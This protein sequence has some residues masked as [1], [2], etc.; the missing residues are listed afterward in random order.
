MHLL[1]RASKK[2]TPALLQRKRFVQAFLFLFG[3]SL[4]FQG[5]S[6]VY[7]FYVDQSNSTDNIFSSATLNAEVTSTETELQDPVTAA[8]MLPDDTVTVTRTAT[9]ENIGTLDF[10]YRA[11]FV[12]NAGSDTAL[13]DALQLTATNDNGFSWTGDLSSFTGSTGNAGTLTVGDDHDWL[14]SIKL[15]SGASASLQDLTCDFDFDFVAWQTNLPDETTGFS[16]MEVITNNIIH[17]AGD[18]TGPVITNLRGRFQPSIYPIKYDDRGRRLFRFN[19][20]WETDEL[21][22]SNVRYDIVNPYPFTDGYAYQSPIAIDTNADNTLHAI[23]ID[24][25]FS[26][27]ADF[28]LYFLVV[29]EDSNGNE[30]IQY[31]TI[32]TGRVQYKNDVVLNEF[33]PNPDSNEPGVNESDEYIELFNR[34]DRPVDVA[35]WAIY[36]SNDSHEVIITPSNTNTG[37]TLILP[38]GRL[39][40]YLEDTILN[41]S[42]GDTVRIYDDALSNG[43]RLVDEYTYTGVAP[44]GKTY[45]RIPDGYGPIVDPEP[46]PGEKNK[47]NKKEIEDFRLYTLE[48]C[49]DGERLNEKADNTLCNPLF[50][51][52][53][54]MID[55]IDDDTLSPVGISLREQIQEEEKEHIKKVR[56]QAKTEEHPKEESAP[57]EEG[58]TEKSDDS[59]EPEEKK[60]EVSKTSP[61]TSGDETNHQ[62]EAVSED[63][64]TPTPEEKLDASEA[65]QE[66]ATPKEESFEEELPIDEL[67]GEGEKEEM[68]NSENSPTPPLDEKTFK[69]E[70]KD[71][72]RKEDSM[73]ETEK[74]STNITKE[75]LREEESNTIHDEKSPEDTGKDADGDSNQQNTTE[76]AKE[77]KP[78]EKSSNL[79]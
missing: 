61:S 26:E 74:S 40:I 17:S 3:V 53:I 77:E 46:T 1:T 65:Q 7:A 32:D 69:K 24:Q 60:E 63:E 49:F 71:T 70:E 15:P 19:I 58:L 20:T 28:P 21:A 64:K 75:K 4:S 78:E 37:D 5:I 36:D 8:N 33:L 13:C 25:D 72:D 76:E 41:N 57:F 22:T 18:L 34:L 6:S 54:G 29:S 12:Q 44:E 51:E 55:D 67:D 56:T 11:R 10:E 48:K 68:L 43:G 50:L 79:N 45:A 23:E 62:Q 2:G 73:Q 30:S 14:F 59:K 35:E 39:V 31:L 38:Y 66:E 47:L 42:G 52:Y 9:I 16:D 27:R